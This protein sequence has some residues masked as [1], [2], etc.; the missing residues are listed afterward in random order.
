M[1]VVGLIVIMFV[2]FL[3]SCLR[4]SLSHLICF[5]TFF[6]III[7][8][9]LLRCF[10]WSR[11]SLCGRNI[12][13]LFGAAS[14]LRVMFRA[15]KTGL[16][17]AQA[18]I[19]YKSIAGRYRPVIYPDG[20]ITTRYRFIKNAYW[21][22]PFSRF[23]TDRSKVVSLLQFFFVRPWFS[24]LSLFCPYLLLTSPCFG[25]FVGLCFVM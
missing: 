4:S 16:R 3:W 13:L 6:F 1:F 22:F 5:I 12:H 24:M 7:I 14:E 17:P 23:P 25:A 11:G 18:S 8:R 20:P 21:D 19:L 15:S 9:V 10:V 2:L